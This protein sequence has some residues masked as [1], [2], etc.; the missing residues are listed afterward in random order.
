MFFQLYDFFFYFYYTLKIV[1]KEKNKRNFI[2]FYML[3]SNF[4]KT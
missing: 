3:F 4:K 1:P 2:P